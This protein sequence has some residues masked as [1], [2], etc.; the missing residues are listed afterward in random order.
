M[1]AD[2][3]AAH[4]CS[5]II[6]LPALRT[7]ANE[8]VRV[9]WMARLAAARL[10]SSRDER[11]MATALQPVIETLSLCGMQ[12]P[13][14]PDEAAANASVLLRGGQIAI[15]AAK[16]VLKPV[17]PSDSKLRFR[18]LARK[19]RRIML[20]CQGHCRVSSGQEKTEP[21]AALQE[22]SA[23]P[24]WMMLT[25]LHL[26]LASSARAA[27]MW[28]LHNY[29][30]VA[31]LRLLEARGRRVQLAE[32][33]PELE[34]LHSRMLASAARPEPLVSTVRALGRAICTTVLQR[35]LAARTFGSCCERATAGCAGMAQEQHK[36]AQAA[37]EALSVRTGLG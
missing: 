34:L 6:E 21:I 12:L 3:E 16:P 29:A 20:G 11:E 18:R 28:A 5:E 37:L 22:D 33:Q 35:P 8:P 7:D 27:G 36:L 26:L 10:R 25:D 9:R 17:G 4:L 24:R 23:L 1:Q 32:R 15:P 19:A 13:V 31:S 14:D 30:T 2:G